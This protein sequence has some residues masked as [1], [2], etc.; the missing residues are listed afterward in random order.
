MST[1]P[2]SVR[3]HLEQ[4]LDWDHKGVDEDL[5]EIAHHMLDW[6][7]HSSRLG[8]TRENVEDINSKHKDK[9]EFQR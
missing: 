5:N 7:L 9:P 4:Q 8:L 3:P 2:E 6:E 1:L